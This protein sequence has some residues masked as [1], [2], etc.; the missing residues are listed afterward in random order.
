MSTS[1]GAFGG[2]IGTRFDASFELVET[3]TTLSSNGWSSAAG[4]SD[5]SVRRQTCTTGTVDIFVN[6]SLV[7]VADASGFTVGATIVFRNALNIDE[8]LVATIAS[9][10]GNEITLNGSAG[11]SVTDEFCLVSST[12]KWFGP[13][14]D[15]GCDCGEVDCLVCTSDMPGVSFSISIAGLSAASSCAGCTVREG[16]FVLT[17]SAPGTC[18]WSRIWVAAEQYNCQL[19]D[20]ADS[21]YIGGSPVGRG[22]FEYMS[23]EITGRQS[24]GFDVRVVIENVY[25]SQSFPQ[26]ANRWTTIYSGQVVSCADL[27]GYVVP[28]ASS[29]DEIILGTSSVGD[30][31]GFDSATITLV[32]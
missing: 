2:P 23:L 1:L 19:F 14:G 15:C 21:V 3:V 17:D 27:A 11:V 26:Y 12:G 28:F 30:F 8:D 18:R 25:L 31:C 10:S 5:S 4:L 6:A 9:I 29:S 20:P 32:G 24:T 13:S 22:A 7:T 16:T